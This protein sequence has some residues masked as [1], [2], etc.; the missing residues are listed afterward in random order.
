MPDWDKRYRE[1]AYDE[2]TE[3]HTLVRRF[4]RLIPGGPVIDIGSG[5]GRD[6]L[7]LAEKGH[8]SIGLEKSQEAL[9][10]A[11]G[12][13]VSTGREL[14]LVRGDAETLPFKRGAAAGVIVF[15]FLERSIMGEIVGLLMKGGILIYQTFLKRQNMIDR[16]RNPNFMLDDGELISYFR[17]LDLLLYE[18]TVTSSKE[19]RRAI[20]QFVGRKP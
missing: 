9:K 6:I 14:H 8:P 15:H 7:F 13:S 3:P 4:A 10:I 11:R 5:S 20:A 19:K 17:D 12:R 16:W 18:E 1:G 2:G